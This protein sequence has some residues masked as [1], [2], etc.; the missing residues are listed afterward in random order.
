MQGNVIGGGVDGL[1]GRQFDRLLRLQAA[2]DG[3]PGDHLQGDGN[4]P[5]DH[6]EQHGFAVIRIT[7]AA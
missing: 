4:Q 6:A 2:S 7:L 3:V 1:H 5:N